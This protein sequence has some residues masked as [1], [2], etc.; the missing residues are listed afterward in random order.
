MMM[1]INQKEITE[2]DALTQ[3]IDEWENE[4][5]GTPISG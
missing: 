5:A 4:L 3:M 2:V 1:T